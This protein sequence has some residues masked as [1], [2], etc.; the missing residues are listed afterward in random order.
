MSSTASQLPADPDAFRMTVGE[1]LEELR[2]RLI[3]ALLGTIGAFILCLA[4]SRQ[5][6]IPFFCRPLIDTLLAYEIN[7]QMYHTGVGDVFGVYIRISLICA[8]AIAAPWS[9]YQL[10]LFIAAGLYPHERRLVTRYIPLSIGLLVVGMVFVYL[11]VLPL[12]LQ[13]FI[14]FSG[15]IEMPQSALRGPESAMVIPDEQRVTLPAIEGDPREPRDLEIWFDKLSQR[16]KIYIDGKVRALQL[17]PASLMAPLITLPEYVN[18]VL[19]MLLLF[20]VSFQLPIVV[21]ALLRAGIFEIQQAKDARRYVYFA[22]VV[23]AAVITPG[24]AVTATIALLLPLIGLY[25]LG[26]LL[27]RGA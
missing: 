2:R 25:E 17:L 9:L 1:H 26:I 4:F 6:V 21:M 12:T 13:F 27:A 10:W 8:I 14:A 5:Y 22:L 18:L 19:M 7:P 24:D 16:P 23:L 3:L 20:G 11:V 15:S